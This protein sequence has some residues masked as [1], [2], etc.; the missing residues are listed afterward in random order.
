MHNLAYF[1]LGFMAVFTAGYYLMS[2]DYLEDFKY[3]DDDEFPG[4]N[5]NDYKDKE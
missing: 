4:L 2:F 1:L 3:D 5:D